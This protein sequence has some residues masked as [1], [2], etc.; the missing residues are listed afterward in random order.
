M[1]RLGGI[2]VCAIL[3]FL[4][5]LSACSPSSNSGQSGQNSQNSQSYKETKSIV[6]D[7]LKSEDGDKAIQQSFNK[8]HDSTTKML[9][10]GEGQQMQMA[11][12]STLTGETGSKLLEKTMTDPRFAGDFAKAIEKSDKQLHKE[13]MKDPEYQKSMLELM[14]NPEFMK[15]MLTVMK[16]TAYR[17]QMNEVIKESLQSPLYKAQLMEM[18][19]KTILDTKEKGS[20][21][22]GKEGG[23]S[24]G[25][26]K[27]SGKGEDSGSTGK[28]SQGGNSSGNE[29]QSQSEDSQDK[30]KDSQK[31]DDKKKDTSSP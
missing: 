21:K 5:V 7:I 26:G 8:N 6:L 27:D 9:M 15:I 10:T 14:N 20:E 19:S 25:Q 30:D 13:L 24:K 22:G 18:F 31:K 11:V 2:R 1:T 28:E 23:E 3:V 4:L 17:T 16:S 29:D 12:K